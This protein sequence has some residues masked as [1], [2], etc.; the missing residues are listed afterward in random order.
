K[1]MHPFPPLQQYPFNNKEP[2]RIVQALLF[3]HRESGEKGFNKV[4]SLGRERGGFW[5][6]EREPF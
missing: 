5:G 2:E 6:G 3:A 1:S 4:E